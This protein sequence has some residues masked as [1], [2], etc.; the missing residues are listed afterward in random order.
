MAH[1]VPFWFSLQLDIFP[2]QYSFSIRSHVTVALPV[3]Q[4]LHDSSSY[5]SES[6]F[7]RLLLRK[8]ICILKKRPN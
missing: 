1:V 6:I 8:D 2:L 4:E 5:I 3:K 7:H